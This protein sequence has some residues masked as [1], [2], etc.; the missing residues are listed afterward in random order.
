MRY[1]SAAFLA[2]LMVWGNTSPV[3]ACRGANNATIVKPIDDGLVTAGPDQYNIKLDPD[4]NRFFI[5]ATEP[6]HDFGFCVDLSILDSS[7]VEK[8]STGVV[9]WGTANVRNNSYY[10]YIRND[11]YR[12]L[13]VLFGKAYELIPWT[14][15]AS[16]KKGLRQK[17]EVDL[18]VTAR[19][20]DIQ[21]NGTELASIVARPSADAQRYGV[22]FQTPKTATGL[23]QVGSPRT[24]K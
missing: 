16:I 11:Q 7:D 15:D 4:I 12:I 19:G 17:N 24:I 14:T 21:I 20:A 5:V 18:R 10:L 22:V 2:A 23:L 3:F 13:H 9:F 6:S 8:T 1:S